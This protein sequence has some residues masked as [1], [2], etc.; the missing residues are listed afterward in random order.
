MSEVKESFLGPG[1]SFE[2]KIS[3]AGSVSIDGNFR[4]EIRAD[5]TLV[6]GETGVVQAKI[7]VQR[8][9]VRGAVSGEVAAKE[10]VD[11]VRR[12]SLEGSVTTPRLRI[13]EGARLEA[14]VTMGERPGRP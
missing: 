12:G 1:T 11:L 14:R 5:G 10:R 8:L 3:F 13:E 4:G 7:D 9:L 2:G 6:V